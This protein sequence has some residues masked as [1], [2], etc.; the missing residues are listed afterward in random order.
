MRTK[1]AF[2][3]LL[4]SAAT[5]SAQTHPWGITF[6]IGNSSS[7]LAA[8]RLFGKQWA[9]LATLGYTSGTAEFSDTAGVGTQSATEWSL[10]VSARRYFGSGE[11]RPFGEAGGGIRWFPG[12]SPCSHP[13]G[14]FASAGGGVEYKLAPRVSIEGTTGLSY[15]S[16]NTRCE[17]NGVITRIHQRTLT[18]FRSSLSLTFYF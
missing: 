10:G 17:D 12:F 16:I 14:P 3:L 2:L 8:R 18:T 13:H 15:S 11:F 5:L 4:F 1:L 9:G 6:G 7:D